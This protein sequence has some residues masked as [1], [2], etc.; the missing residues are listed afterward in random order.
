MRYEIL[1]MKYKVQSTKYKVQS[2]ASHNMIAIIKSI[3]YHFTLYITDESINHHFTLYAT[4]NTS[5]SID[6]SLKKV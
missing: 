6:K 4:S 3:N 1:S 5:Q 2:I